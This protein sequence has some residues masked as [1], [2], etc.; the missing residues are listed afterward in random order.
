MRGVRGSPFGSPCGGATLLT[1]TTDCCCGALSTAVDGARTARAAGA[2]ARI[3][4]LMATGIQMRRI[5][6]DTR[7]VVRRL[8]LLL[9]TVAAL[10]ISAGAA[11][12]DTLYI[13]VA[14]RSLTAI[15]PGF[16]FNPRTAAQI[17]AADPKVRR[18]AAHAGGE[19]VAVP[20]LFGGGECLV[21]FYRKRDL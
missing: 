19:L 11:R 17:A 21:R 18:V 1:G 13:P 16:T 7:R 15:P 12:A 14:P 5:A 20:A 9:L 3:A 8:A 4:T 6:A 10:G 2:D